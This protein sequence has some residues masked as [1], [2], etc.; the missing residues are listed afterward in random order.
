MNIEPNSK[1]QYKDGKRRITIL[2][3]NLV[4]GKGIFFDVNIKQ[5]S[6]NRTFRGGYYIAGALNPVDAHPDT[7]EMLNAAIA[8]NS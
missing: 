2:F 3:G 7:V 8:A 1:L 6:Q 4:V 5:A